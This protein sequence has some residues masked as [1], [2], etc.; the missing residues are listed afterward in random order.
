[1]LVRG[2]GNWNAPITSV[3]VVPCFH[4]Y[5]NEKEYRKRIDFSDKGSRKLWDYDEK[6]VSRL[7]TTMPMTKCSGSSKGL[8]NYVDDV[9]QLQF[10]ILVE[11]REKIYMWTKEIAEFRLH[12]H[13]ERIGSKNN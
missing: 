2:K 10:D 5:L 11:D 9:F 6:G 7:I 1:M 13:F 4:K 3:E 8:I 12:V